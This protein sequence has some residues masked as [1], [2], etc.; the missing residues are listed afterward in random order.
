MRGS[1]SLAHT[2]QSFGRAKGLDSAR[3]TARPQFLESRSPKSRMQSVELSRAICVHLVAPHQARTHHDRGVQPWLPRR[4]HGLGLVS[5]CPHTSRIV[6]C[7]RR[8]GT[9]AH[10]VFM[11]HFESGRRPHSLRFPPH[12]P[13]LP[14]TSALIVDRVRD[15]ARGSRAPMHAPQQV[16]THAP[17][18][19]AAISDSSRTTK[20]IR[21]T[22]PAQQPLGK[23]GCMMLWYGL[24]V[25]SG[26]AK[27]CCHQETFLP[28]HSGKQTRTVDH[29][30]RMRMTNNSNLLFSQL[31]PNVSRDAQCFHV[32]S[33][34]VFSF[35]IFPM[36][37]MFQ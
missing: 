7:C 4:R 14:K 36:L 10:S 26:I 18:L 16:Q 3:G 37:P 21:A 32:S 31:I 2:T 5:Q 35:P 24:Q 8:D 25:P 19:L 33:F 28:R 15:Y 20:I 23:G 9:S 1:T 29:E 12:L 27:P 30:H 13:Q 11:Q 17:R 6:G 34:S 22:P